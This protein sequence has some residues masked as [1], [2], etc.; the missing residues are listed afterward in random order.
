MT[1]TTY[2]I[3]WLRSLLAYMSVYLKDP[4]PLH[5]NVIYIARNSVFHEETKHIKTDCH[6]TRHHLE[7]GIISLP[8][9]PSGL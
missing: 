8:F 2:E 1:L 4:T 3:I 7:L 5:K 9:V 6:F